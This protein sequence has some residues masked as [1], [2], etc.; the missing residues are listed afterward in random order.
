MKLKDYIQGKRHGKDANRL[1]RK[2]MDDPFLQD[3]LDGFDAVEDNH[4]EAIDL[5]QERIAEQLA[6][7]SYQRKKGLSIYS[8][9]Y[10]V[11]VAASVAL[12][13]G[14]GTFFFLNQPK[15]N[16]PVLAMDTTLSERRSE[17]D[18]V[19]E[20]EQINKDEIAFTL[21]NVCDAMEIADEE[22]FYADADELSV[23]YL[24]F[25]DYAEDAKISVVAENAAV[26][27]DSPLAYREEVQVSKKLESKDKQSESRSAFGDK[28]EE[29]IA[30]E[31]VDDVSGI[32]PKVT[33]VT[34][35]RGSARGESGEVI[36]NKKQKESKYSFGENE[37][38]KHFEEKRAKNICGTDKIKI[39]AEFYINEVGKPTDI[40]VTKS[41]CE[42]LTKEFIQLLENSP[43]WTTVGERVKLR[44]N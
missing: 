15:E 44:I 20:Q 41:T 40:K 33:G 26:V 3:A 31:P 43:R 14:V 5:L 2:A 24:D 19:Q 29:A 32:V 42:E 25:A 36:V 16:P 17:V 9:W 6:V 11:S 8:R 28:K 23:A 10:L 7:S 21:P 39:Q 38:R 30:L 34:N 22:S 13:V 4:I 35:E 27:A 37:F 1:E 18:I 12:L